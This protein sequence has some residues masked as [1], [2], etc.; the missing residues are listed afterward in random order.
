MQYYETLFFVTTTCFVSEVSFFHVPL[1]SWLYAIIMSRTSFRV[2][3]HSKVCLNVKEL[4]GRSRRYIWSLRDSNE[5]R[6]QNHL[7]CKRTLNRLAK[8]ACG[9]GI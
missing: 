2:N 3:L 7:V 9:C 1:L 5:I 4:F 6:T 8:L